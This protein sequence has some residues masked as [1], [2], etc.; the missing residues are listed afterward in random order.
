L[1]F[2]GTTPTFVEC[3]LVNAKPPLGSVL[4]R[5]NLAVW[6]FD[7]QVGVEIVNIDGYDIEVPQYAHRQHGHYDGSDYVY[8][9]T[10]HLIDD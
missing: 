10:D 9:E 2:G 6:E 1:D 7:V 8:N 5:C 4:V 3:N